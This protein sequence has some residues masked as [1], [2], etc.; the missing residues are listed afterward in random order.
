METLYDANGSIPLAD[1][2]VKLEHGPSSP[3]QVVLRLSPVPT[4]H[5]DLLEPSQEFQWAIF[6]AYLENGSVAIELP[7]G[8]RLQVSD[9]GQSLIL[10]SVPVTVW[11]AGKPLHSVRF[12]LINFP[13]FIQP[14]SA[15]AQTEE[16]ARR[17]QEALWAIQLK[18]D[19]WLVDLRPV[20]NREH[21][22]RSLKDQRGFALTHWGNVTR[23]DGEAFSIESVRPL[24]K[25]LR[26]FFSFARGVKCGITLVKG[27]GEAG[28]T[29]WEEWGVTEVQPWKGYRSCLDLHNGAALGDLFAGFFRY[30][31][32]LPR[33]SKT[34]LALEW[35]LQSN[36]QEA[37]H[38]SMILNQAA[39][40]RLAG[41]TVGDRKE[42]KIGCRTKREQPGRWIARALC[43]VEVDTRIPPSLGE[44]LGKAKSFEH[45]PHALVYLRDGLVHGEM[46]DGIPSPQAQIQARN[47]G[48]WYVELL[49][50]KLVCY[51][52]VYSNRL[53]S[54]WDGEFETVPWAIDA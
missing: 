48:L 20:G 9:G 14:H 27:L 10:Q 35:Y 53:A 41:E 1:I 33:D 40:E 42:E 52:G 30:F 46:K 2:I 17:N 6:D 29:V 16:E 15:G 38:T 49:L 18:G 47:L 28:E 22:H 11:D 31:R 26:D 44:A 36:A 8:N 21:V 13:D 12:G 43:K 5:F 51:S 3:A 45:G 24:M 7:C 54:R 23:L 25:A 34:Q 50:L 4:I 32:A 37:P 19:P 39:L